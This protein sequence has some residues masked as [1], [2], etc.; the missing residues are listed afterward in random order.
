MSRM[1]E[2]ILPKAASEFLSEA[3]KSANSN[4]I[5]LVGDEFSGQ[6]AGKGIESAYR[7]EGNSLAFS[8]V[9]KPLFM[10]WPAIESVVRNYFI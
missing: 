10:P 2:V 4:G 8:I 6:F 5:H 7:I 3:R 1:F 9:K